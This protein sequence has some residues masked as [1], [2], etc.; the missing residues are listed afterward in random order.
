M[1]DRNG[2]KLSLGQYVLVH[3]SLCDKC[4]VGKIIRSD[5]AENVGPNGMIIKCKIGNLF[6]HGSS[7]TSLTDDE[8]ILELLKRE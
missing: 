7:L 1:T 8:A 2:K 3:Y 6:F 4:E 5:N